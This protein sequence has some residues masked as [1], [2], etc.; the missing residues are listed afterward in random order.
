MGWCMKDYEWARWYPSRISR[1]KFNTFAV[2]S[3]IF[4]GILLANRG[5]IFDPAEYGYLG[6]VSELEKVKLRTFSPVTVGHN[7]ANTA[8]RLKQSLSANMD[9]I[10]ADV[11]YNNRSFWVGH[12]ERIL[13]LFSYDAES[14]GGWLGGPKMYLEDLLLQTFHENKKFLFD[15]KAVY[16]GDITKLL[17]FAF[18]I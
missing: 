13:G 3:L 14:K 8:Y 9:F 2:S 11:S 1:R 18:Q 12:E 6:R 4:G 5:H 7:G 10:E 16:P 17:K 15:L